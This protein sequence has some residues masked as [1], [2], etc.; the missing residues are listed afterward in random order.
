[1]IHGTYIYYLRVK[2]DIH[3]I[4]TSKI[5]RCS[6]CTM[7]KIDSNLITFVLSGLNFQQLQHFMTHGL[8][9]TIMN[10][11]ET[12]AICRT[13]VRHVNCNKKE[14]QKIVPLSRHLLLQ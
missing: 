6:T 13:S 3:S 7:H 9:C 10:R 11:N 12:Q 8:Q 5:K 4:K 1:M 2:I 14:Y